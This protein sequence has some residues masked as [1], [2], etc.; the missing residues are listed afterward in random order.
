VARV[1][2]KGQITI[3]K[4]VRDRLGLEEGTEV[5]LVVE[6]TSARLRKVAPP[7]ALERWFG[8]LSL[9]GGVDDFVRRLREDE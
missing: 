8:A 9:P 2:S 4:E 3:P 1:T 6:G 5:E 7:D